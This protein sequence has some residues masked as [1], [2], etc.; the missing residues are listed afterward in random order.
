MRLGQ[1]ARKVSV[2]PLE[3]VEFLAKRG[4]IVEESANARIDDSDAQAVIGHFA[5]HLLKTEAVDPETAQVPEA[6]FEEVTVEEITE[7]EQPLEQ[8]PTEQLLELPAESELNPEPEPI[9]E[10]SLPDLIKA[11]KVELKGLKVVGKIELPEPKKK[12]DIGV[13]QPEVP[14]GT[15]DR[16]KKGRDRERNQRNPRG[17][18][19]PVAMERE[20]LAREAAEKK[21]RQLQEEKERR[22][23]YYASKVKP[24]S[25][26]KSVRI[27]DEPVSTLAD[28]SP[29]KPKGLLRRFIHWLTT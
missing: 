28:E 19:N 24:S 8:E 11:P 13:K 3:V 4:I 1:L 12:E 20:R 10:E 22:K 17:S 18:K 16:E 14:T 27:F 15:R 9:Q 25:P 23:L 6:I 5:P 7:I 29:E 21:Q 2:R 26:S